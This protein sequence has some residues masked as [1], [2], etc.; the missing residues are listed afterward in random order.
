MSIELIKCGLADN[1]DTFILTPHM[2]YYDEALQSKIE[3]H[4]IELKRS[5]AELFPNV[6]IYLGGEIHFTYDL[7]KYIEKFRGLLG[8]KSDYLLLEFPF[9]QVPF[10]AIQVIEKVIQSGIK[11]IIAHPERIR[12][13]TENNQLLNQMQQSGCLFQ[14]TAGSL[15][16]SFGN[17]I[18]KSAWK[19]LKKGFTDFIASDVHHPEWRPFGMKNAYNAV[20]DQ[21]GLQIAD[22]LFYN[23]QQKYLLGEKSV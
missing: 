11:I 7:F 9:E 8:V 3:T 22:K 17:E 16:G 20:K 10:T 4:F 18:K 13:L 1:I 5:V 14:I 23:N 21:S 6:M 12:G 2:N 19:L 15:N